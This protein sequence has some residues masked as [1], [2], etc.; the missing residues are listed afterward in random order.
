MYLWHVFRPCHLDRKSCGDTKPK[1]PQKNQGLLGVLVQGDEVLAFSLG[2]LGF[3]DDIDPKSDSK[4]S[5]AAWQRS[6]K[7]I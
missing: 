7:W 1:S 3:N 4:K 5:M 6:V 2:F